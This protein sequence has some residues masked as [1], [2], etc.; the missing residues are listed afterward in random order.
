M[1]RRSEPSADLAASTS[2]ARTRSTVSGSFTCASN[3]P[4]PLR[5]RRARTYPAWRVRGMQRVAVPVVDERVTD[6]GAGREGDEIAAAHA[7]QLAVD[8]RVELALD[9]VDELL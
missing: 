6:A 2:S 7:V 9:D 8:P 5:R 3:M 1:D 4:L